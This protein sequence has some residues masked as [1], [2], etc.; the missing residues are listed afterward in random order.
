MSHLAPASALEYSSVQTSNLI[1]LEVRL[2]QRG[3]DLEGRREDAGDAVLREV[4][5]LQ[6]R[7]VRLKD[8]GRDRW[9]GVL[10]EDQRF[11]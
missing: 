2:H 9:E 3:Q 10:G 8:L 6:I 1:A 5:L 11:Q 7:E 4:E